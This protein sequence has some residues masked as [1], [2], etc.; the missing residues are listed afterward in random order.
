MLV[1]DILP[2]W[3]NPQPESHPTTYDQKLESLVYPATLDSLIQCN[4]DR[5]DYEV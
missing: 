3:C 5:F 2:D 4:D 1:A